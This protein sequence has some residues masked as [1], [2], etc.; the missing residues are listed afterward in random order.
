MA[1]FTLPA[2]SKVATGKTVK[3]DAG[4]TN[5]R[6]FKIYRYDPDSGDNPCLDTFEIDLDTCDWIFGE[7]AKTPKR[8]FYDIYI[9]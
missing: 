8:D 2:N 7:W 6:T 5:V 3:A 1:E 9:R 4:A